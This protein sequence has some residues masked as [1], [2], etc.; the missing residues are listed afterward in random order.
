M[1]DINNKNV[2]KSFLYD[3]EKYAHSKFY[4][5]KTHASDILNLDYD[6]LQLLPSVGVPF[7]TPNEEIVKLTEKYLNKE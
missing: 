4:S 3:A 5:H 2:M 1:C 7:S 6:N